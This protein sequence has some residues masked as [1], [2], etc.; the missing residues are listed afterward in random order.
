[1]ADF[2]AAGP[3]TTC[4]L[5]HTLHRDTQCPQHGPQTAR[6]CGEQ[7][8]ALTCGFAP[9]FGPGP[10]ALLPALTGG[11]GR[12]PG[13]M[14]G[15]P[16][17]CRGAEAAGGGVSLLLRGRPGPACGF[18]LFPFFPCY[19][20]ICSG[21]FSS[22]LL[23]R[24]GPS[25]PSAAGARVSSRGPVTTHPFALSLQSR[26]TTWATVPCARVSYKQSA[27][28]VSCQMRGIL[29]GLPPQHGMKIC[30]WCR[31][32]QSPV[33]NRGPSGGHPHCAVRC[34]WPS[35]PLATLGWGLWARPAWAR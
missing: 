10:D 31:V 24:A 12:G 28:A 30:P 22:T 19:V 9:I 26:P 7:G 32:P 3:W 6:G 35:T 33:C 20:L 4:G 15:A 14:R 27:S 16:A 18:F 17:E 11:A 5:A 21:V 25:Q 34:P 8:G 1:M 2:H 23:Q 13:V 29:L